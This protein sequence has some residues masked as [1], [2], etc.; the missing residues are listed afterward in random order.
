ML[1]VIIEEKGMP[2]S[3]KLKEVLEER[4]AIVQYTGDNDEEYIKKHSSRAGETCFLCS[5]KYF[6][7]INGQTGLINIAKD[8]KANSIV[9]VGQVETSFSV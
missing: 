4:Q 9:V 8:Y 3:Q 5:K 2:S 1:N 7:S 6:N